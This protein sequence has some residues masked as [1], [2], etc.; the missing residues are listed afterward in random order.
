MRL[1]IPTESGH[2]IRTNAATL[3]DRERRERNHLAGPT[4]L[5][6][7]SISTMLNCYFLVLVFGATPA[8]A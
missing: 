2:L 4:E 1:S 7:T 6:D 5:D 3:L 8:A